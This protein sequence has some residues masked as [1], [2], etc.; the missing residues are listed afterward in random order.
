MANTSVSR[1]LKDQLL[2]KENVCYLGR[3]IKNTYPLFQ[4]PQFEKDILTKFPQLELKK[5][6]YWIRKNLEKYLPNDYEKTLNIL[7]KS[8][9]N[10]KE[11]EDFIFAAY[12]DFVSE[13]G[14]NKKYLDI[15]LNALGDFTKYFSAEFAIRPFINNFS[16]ITFIKIKEWSLSSHFHQRRLASEGLRPK[17]PWA[18]GI[19]FD[20]KKGV[21]ILDNLFYDQ[22]RYVTRSVANHLNDISKIDPDFVL[23]C[24]TVWKKLK[25]QNDKE[26]NYIIHHSLRT[27][28][29]KG[30]GNTFHFLGYRSDFKIDIQNFKGDK[31]IITLGDTLSFSF[32]LVSQKDEKII[33]DYKIIYPTPQKRISEKVFKIKKIHIKKDEKVHIIKKHLFKKMTT[34]KLYEGEYTLYIQM[35][36]VLLHSISFYLRKKDHE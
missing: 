36:G 21:Q 6:I 15:S 2:H 22:E 20:Y 13:N 32:D 24:L 9:E 5:R 25:K 3:L 23:E 34:K 27:S 11:N 35:N 7:L 28:I 33:L 30:H 31:D 4:K 18:Q 10:H 1:L 12:S 8:L 19:Q 14:C 29:K 26:M 16:E 17:L